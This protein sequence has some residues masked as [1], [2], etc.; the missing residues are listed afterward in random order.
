M[1]RI[2][3][4]TIL[5]I[6]ADEMIFLEGLRFNF[7][8]RYDLCMYQTRNTLVYEQFKA[9]DNVQTKHKTYRKS[10]K[11]SRKQTF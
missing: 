1:A 7:K 5:I 4:T 10:L 3:K 6:Y 2:Q 9:K 8:F 11:R